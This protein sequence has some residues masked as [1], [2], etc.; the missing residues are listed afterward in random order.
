MPRQINNQ[1]VTADND[2]ITLTAR[3]GEALCT[4]V[5]GLIRGLALGDD[6]VR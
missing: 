5:T 6:N 2:T 4:A 1:G 3:R